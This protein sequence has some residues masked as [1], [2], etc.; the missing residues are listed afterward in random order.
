MCNEMKLYWCLITSF[1]FCFMDWFFISLFLSYKINLNFYLLSFLPGFLPWK[2]Y[3]HLIQDL[4]CPRLISNL[5][6]N[7]FKILINVD[8][9]FC[10][11]YLFFLAINQISLYSAFFQIKRLLFMKITKVKLNLQILLLKIHLW[12]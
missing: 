8:Y 1:A 5:K 7:Q 9:Q 10:L 12:R 4:E 2:D 3:L 11:F 6:K